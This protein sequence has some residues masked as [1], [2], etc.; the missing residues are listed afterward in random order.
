MD[1]WLYVRER[2]L[3]FEQVG[4]FS[5]D[6]YEGL[7]FWE[8]GWHGRNAVG[9]RFRACRSAREL[10]RSGQ[11]RGRKPFL[12]QYRPT[13]QMK[14]T[15]ISLVLDVYLSNLYPMVLQIE[16]KRILLVDDHEIIRRGLHVFVET[17]PGLEVCAEAESA[18][19]AL[20]KCAEFSPDIALIDLSLG[21]DS[22][23]DLIKEIAKRFP[24]VKTLAV[25]MLDE[26]IYAERVL[27]A[28]GYGFISKS[29]ST[30]QLVEAV[31]CVLDG[32]P[33][34]S[35]TVMRR[36]LQSVR[37]ATNGSF[38]KKLS[39]RELM[40]FEQIGDGK[41]II[42]I[43]KLMSLS[44]KTVETYRA[45][46]KVKLSIGTSAELTRTAMRWHIEQA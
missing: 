43:A 27:K 22:G 39:D 31:R 25:S 36:V 10:F 17:D 15:D 21:S 3:S 40:V 46:I 4:V 14:I 41:S 5:L 44:P 42:G 2:V 23:L 32:E 9:R 19:E 24:D 30:R 37:Q 35:S 45:R 13:R 7:D 11:K 38:L 20:E 1:S 6:F 33:Y 18:A 8:P 26:Q 12:N 16:K 28:G 29:V 34:A